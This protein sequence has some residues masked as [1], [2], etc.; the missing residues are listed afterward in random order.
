MCNS[1]LFSEVYIT[2]LISL[3]YI[4]CIEVILY[5]FMYMWQ[6]MYWHFAAVFCWPAGS[7]VDVQWQTKVTALLFLQLC[8]WQLCLSLTNI[9]LCCI[10]YTF[11]ITKQAA[12]WYAS[13]LHWCTNTKWAV[14]CRNW[15]VGGHSRLLRYYAVSPGMYFLMFQMRAVPLC[16]SSLLELTSSNCQ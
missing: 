7:S 3:H 10:S 6:K 14:S 13:Y 1:W 8:F 5:V 11:F 2:C 4:T 15:C 16:S 9:I 12:G